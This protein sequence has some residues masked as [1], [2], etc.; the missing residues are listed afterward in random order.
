MECI[1]CKNDKEH[2]LRKEKAI[3]KQL[4][5]K[6]LDKLSLFY[7]ILSDQT[8]LKILIALL[9]TS[10]CVSDLACIFD[11]TLSAISHQLKIL[12]MSNLVKTTRQGKEIYYTLCDDHIK[13][14]LDIAIIHIN[15]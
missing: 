4:D 8:R 3:E 7:K 1:L 9:D 2:E 6:T 15:E 11:M 13:E 10:L 12:R 5:N 14:I